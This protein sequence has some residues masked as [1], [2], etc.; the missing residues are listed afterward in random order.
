M[1]QQDQRERKKEGTGNRKKTF[2]KTRRTIKIY[3]LE[4]KHTKEKKNW[5]IITEPLVTKRPRNNMLY[6]ENGPTTLRSKTIK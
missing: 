5:V 6:E 4:I 3:E 2:N 1:K